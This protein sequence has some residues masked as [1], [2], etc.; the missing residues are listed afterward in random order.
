[1][2]AIEELS[3]TNEELA[4]DV[5]RE[6]LELAPNGFI[7]WKHNAV[8]SAFD[9]KKLIRENRLMVADNNELKARLSTLEEDIREVK[10]L[11]CE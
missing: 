7:H 6:A 9:T 8:K 2:Q 3:A 11:L 1:M 10:Q 4:N 5:V